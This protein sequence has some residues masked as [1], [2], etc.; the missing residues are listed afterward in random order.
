M[1]SRTPASNVAGRSTELGSFQETEP[2][3]GVR[4]H[5]PS[6]QQPEEPPVESRQSSPW[7]LQMEPEVMT[8]LLGAL[9]GG[10]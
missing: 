4:P 10:P 6:A 3:T 9:I 2:F 1:K 8:S 7:R 5:E